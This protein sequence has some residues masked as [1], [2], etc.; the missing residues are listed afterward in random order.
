MSLEQLGK[1]KSSPDSGYQSYI[2]SCIAGLLKVR[3][4]NTCTNFNMF[5]LKHT[6]ACVDIRGFTKYVAKPFS[7]IFPPKPPR[8]PRAVP[9][10]HFD[11]FDGQ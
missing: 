7:S 8:I 6:R 9:N 2:E 5:V 3:E 1:S 11:W 10:V 4:A